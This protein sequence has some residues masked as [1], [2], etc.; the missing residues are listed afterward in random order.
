VKP[1]A[2]LQVWS[3]NEVFLLHSS[4]SRFPSIS[5]PGSEFVAVLLYTSFVIQTAVLQLKFCCPKKNNT[6]KIATTSSKIS[7]MLKITN[8][9]DTGAPK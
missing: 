4:A 7:A 1:R 9:D 5:Y 2:D 8:Y 3:C 6:L